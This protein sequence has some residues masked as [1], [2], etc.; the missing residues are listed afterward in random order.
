MNYN[1]VSY[2]LI[3]IFLHGQER[4]GDG[5]MGVSMRDRK[6]LTAERHSK[7]KRETVHWYREVQ[8]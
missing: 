3:L 6:R 8:L 1:C 4:R 5:R 2:F 7:E